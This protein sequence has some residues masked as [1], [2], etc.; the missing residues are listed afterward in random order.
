MLERDKQRGDQHKKQ[1]REKKLHEQSEQE[2]KAQPQTEE[3]QAEMATDPA[4]AR[5]E[6]YIE[7]MNEKTQK[8]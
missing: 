1:K 5:D 6:G 4:A 7:R 8:H 2:Q 3:R